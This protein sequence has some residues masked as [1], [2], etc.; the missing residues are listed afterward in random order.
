MATYDARTHQEILNFGSG[1][2][3]PVDESIR[4]PV[5]GML[6]ERSQLILNLAAWGQVLE[7][8]RSYGVRARLRNTEPLKPF[9]E[10]TYS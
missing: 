4:K 8:G 10:R 7:A 3:L 2:G 6:L 1:N 5:I 9:H